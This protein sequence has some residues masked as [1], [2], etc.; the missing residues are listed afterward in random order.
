M[1]QSKFILILMLFLPWFS[2]PL[3]GKKTIKR[4]WPAGLFISFI[5]VLENILAEKRRWWQFYQTLYPKLP[6]IFPLIFGP[7]LIGSMWI[8]KF[9]YGRFN[10]FLIVNL[11]VDSLFTFLVTN[12][13]QRWGI[14][15]LVRLK[16][17]QLS[18]LFF[19]KS[20]LLYGFQYCKEQS[21]LISNL[22]FRKRR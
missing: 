10:L 8:L 19:I 21:S 15:S 5:L 7:F 1:K 3:L 16:K 9:F 14:A 11:A 4:F 2:I 20:L 22:G 12:Q 17:Y 6:G 13:L 18:L